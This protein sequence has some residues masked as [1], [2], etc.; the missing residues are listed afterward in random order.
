MSTKE[1]MLLNCSAEEDS[2]KSLGLHKE[3]KPI[4]PKGNQ[5]RIIHWKDWCWSWSSNT[6]DYLM[7][8]VDSLEKILMLRNWKQKE[9]G[10]QGKRC[11]DSTTNS[12]NL[13]VSKFQEIVVG[14]G[15][16]FEFQRVRHDLATEQVSIR[17]D[18]SV[19]KYKYENV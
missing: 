18:L 14:R 19:F 11:L 12:M 16:P 4:N 9:K 5:T 8:R 6:F 7:G 2:W 15:G 17:S 13:N 3:I 1:L 10:W